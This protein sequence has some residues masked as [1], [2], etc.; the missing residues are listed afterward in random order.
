MCIRDSYD[1]IRAAEVSRKRGPDVGSLID[2]LVGDGMGLLIDIIFDIIEGICKQ[3]PF[4]RSWP[5]WLKWIVFKILRFILKIVLTIILFPASITTKLITDFVQELA[6]GFFQQI[7]NA[8]IM[9]F[10]QTA[11]AGILPSSLSWMFTL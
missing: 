6:M 3:N 11:V 5:S 10:V 9:P 7:S 4:I 8:I 2:S 1:R